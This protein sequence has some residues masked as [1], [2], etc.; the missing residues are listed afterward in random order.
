MVYVPFLCILQ[1]AYHAQNEC[2]VCVLQGV[3]FTLNGSG[4]I[5]TI[6]TALREVLITRMTLIIMFKVEQRKLLGSS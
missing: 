2:V 5:P 3:L 6:C 4:N 1:N